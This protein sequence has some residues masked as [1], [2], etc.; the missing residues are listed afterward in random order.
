MCLGV[1]GQIIEVRGKTAVVDFW[2]T[3]KD[4]LLDILEVPVAAGDYIVNHAGYA[5]RRVPD[6]QVIDTLAM[7]E[8]VLCETG[9]DPLAL[10]FEHELE[11]V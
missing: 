2:G 3:R 11:L 10:E 1:P 6:D 5:I 9:E 7:Y 4:V 8:I